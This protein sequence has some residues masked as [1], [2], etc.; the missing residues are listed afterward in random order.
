MTN[1]AVPAGR[2]T[3]NQW[4]A[5][6]WGIRTIG[7]YKSSLPPLPYR[8]LPNQLYFLLKRTV[9]TLLHVNPGS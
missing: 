2:S 9:P 1:I 7:R 5:T 6:V 8:V 4:W 3:S